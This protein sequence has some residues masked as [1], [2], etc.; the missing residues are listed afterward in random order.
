MMAPAGIELEM[1]VSEPDALTTRPLL[2]FYK[3]KCLLFQIESD[4]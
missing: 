2:I 4:K 1:L 3:R